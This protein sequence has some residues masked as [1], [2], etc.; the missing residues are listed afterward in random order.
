MLEAVGTDADTATLCCAA[1]APSPKPLSCEPPRLKVLLVEDDASTSVMIERCLVHMAAFEPQIAVAGTLKSATFALGA[2]DFDVVL[3]DDEML[4]LDGTNWLMSLGQPWQRC[5]SVL[6]TGAGY[7]GMG[8]MVG[9]GEGSA[10]LAKDNLSPK[11]LETTILQAIRDHA[12]YCSRAGMSSE[13]LACE[14][15]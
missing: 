3:I 14:E 2:D 5:A 4:M 13:D 8:P 6:L 15:T 9:D 1:D 12:H 10:C 11:R 7:A